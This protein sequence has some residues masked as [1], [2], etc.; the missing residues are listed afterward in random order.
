MATSA[1]RE[2]KTVMG[3]CVD[4]II[5]PYSI[6]KPSQSE[7]SVTQFT[8]PALRR[9]RR[10]HSATTTPHQPAR[11]TD[12]AGLLPVAETEHI[13]LTATHGCCKNRCHNQMEPGHG[14]AVDDVSRGNRAQW[15][16][17]EGSARRDITRM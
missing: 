10:T 5:A 13:P 8:G 14:A 3:S 4:V 2:S 16:C 7:W 15:E 9:A 11:A 6:T 17:S 12:P 1:Q